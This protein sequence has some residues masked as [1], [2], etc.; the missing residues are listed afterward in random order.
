M[1]LPDANLR[2]TPLHAL[3]LSLG[4]RMVP[5]AGY[6]MPVQYPGGLIAEHHHTRRAAS[7]F[8]V[9]HMGQLR[10]VGADAAAAFETL[11]P[12]DVQGLA[13]GKQRY[14][15]LLHET[16]GILDDLMFVQ[17]G[18]DLLVIVNGACKAADMAHIQAR[19]GLRCQVLP[20][21]E[22]ALLALQGPLAATALQRL[23]PGIEHLVFM[24][25]DHFHVRH[26]AQDI[27]C[28]ITRSG[29]TGE[30]GFEISVPAADAITLARALLA[31]RR[32]YVTIANIHHYFRL[33]PDHRLV[34]GGRA[35]FAISSP[36]SDATSGEILRRGL[37]EMF[38]QLA[39]VRLEIA[40]EVSSIGAIIDLVGAGYGHAVLHASAVAASGRAAML[41]V[42]PLVEAIAASVQRTFGRPITVSV[43]GTPA[44]RFALPEAES[45]PI[46]LT[47]NELLTNAIKHGAPGEIRCVL[48]GDEARLAM[49]FVGLGLVP[50]YASSLLL[51]QLVGHQRAAEKL[52]L[53]DPFTPEQAVECGIANG[54][55]FIH[56]QNFGFKMCCN[57]KC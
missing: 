25:G 20:L 42:R 45:I 13:V 12:V 57:G 18:D 55:H 33:T 7:L 29:Y 44:H 24:S 35:R 4:A 17:R 51:P 52:L 47:V 16:G 30:D 26:S 9:S 23:C 28:Y 48:E 50:E 32:T 14:G 39:G 11:M 8:D 10:L 6:A 1:S 53:G 34:F 49:P 21:P 38:P 41:R 2:T 36:Q 43:Q 22:R 46:A 37:T 19:I 27:D 56:N 54:K 3:H 15:L 5:V 31:G 40:W